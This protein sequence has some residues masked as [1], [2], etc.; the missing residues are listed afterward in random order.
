MARN[1]EFHSVKRD[2]PD[3]GGAMEKVEFTPKKAKDYKPR[4]GGGYT[5]TSVATGPKQVYWQCMED[6]GHTVNES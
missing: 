3:C 2:C 1:Q 5:K 4:K 6:F